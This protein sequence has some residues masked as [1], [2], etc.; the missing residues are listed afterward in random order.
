MTAD[1]AEQRTRQC[2]R[3][4]SGLKDSGAREDVGDADDLR[5]VLG[6]DHRG[7]PWHRQHEVGQQRSQGKVGHTPRRGHDNALRLPKQIVVGDRSLMSVEELAGLQRDS[8]QLALGVTQLDPVSR[9]R[10]GCQQ[11]LTFQASAQRDS[12]A[13]RCVRADGVVTPWLGWW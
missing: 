12:L 10:M 11:Q 8:V 9:R 6:V 7:A 1:S 3:S 5:G 2:A 13:A 4:D